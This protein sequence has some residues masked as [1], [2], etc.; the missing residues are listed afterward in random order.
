MGTIAIEC[1]VS[2]LYHVMADNLIVE[3]LRENGDP[4]DFNEVGQVVITD[5]HNFAM[6]LIRY[7][8]GD[9]AEKGGSCSCGRGLPTL[10]K[11]CGRERNLAILPNGKKYW[12]RIG[13]NHFRTIAPIEQ[14]QL[15]QESLQNIEVRLVVSRTLMGNEEQ[16]L[17]EIICEKMG[18]PF[19]LHFTYFEKQIPRGENGKFE[20]FICRVPVE[21]IFVHTVLSLNV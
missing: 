18:F 5:L 2:G 11:I 4:C 15:I 10:K 6:P 9:Y 3:V 14:Y 1:P 12:P 21:L 13:F 17:R 19:Q 20:E 7:A 16:A 8:T